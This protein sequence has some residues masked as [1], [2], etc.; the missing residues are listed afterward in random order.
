MGVAGWRSWQM[1]GLAITS[2]ENSNCCATERE[3]ITS[4]ILC[5][6]QIVEMLSISD[7]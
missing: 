3:E 4:H 7:I 6:Q 5:R 2:A 1:P